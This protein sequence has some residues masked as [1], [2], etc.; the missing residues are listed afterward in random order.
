MTQANPFRKAKRSK[1]HLKFGLAGPSGAGKTYSALK[2]IKGFDGTEEWA[3]KTVVIDTED[4]ADLY[5]KLGEF[6]VLDFKPPY[7]P[8]RLIKAID[9]CIENSFQ[10]IILDSF[11]K[12]WDGPGG[13]LE[14]HD[15]MGGKYQDWAKVNPIWDSMVQKIVHC[16]AHMIVT[17]RKKQE[18][19]MQQKGNRTVVEKMGMKS[20][21]REGFEYELTAAL[22]LNMDHVAQVSKD[23]TN[24][25]EEI[26]PVVLNEEH[27]EI[28]A[29][30]CK[31]E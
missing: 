29:K 6:S 20:M 10:Y 11:T 16:D 31:G 12:F 28:L 7:D 4:S 18:Y 21:T 3:E 9:L 14:I 19:T 24:L 8:R 1:I 17:M 15:K 2:L 23:R 25:F 22:D 26:C 13:T 5:D 27:G 30:W